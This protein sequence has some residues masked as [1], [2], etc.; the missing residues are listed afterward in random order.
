MPQFKVICTGSSGFIGSA[1]RTKLENNPDY[2]VYTLPHYILQDYEK[3]KSEIGV[4]QP[5]FIFHLAGFGNHSTQIDNQETF[6]ANVIGIWNLLQATKDIPYRAFINFGSSSEYGQ[7]NTP[8]SEL[9]LPEASTMYGCTKIA[10]TY[11][12]RAFAR[13]YDKP[14]VTVRPFSVFGPDE[15]DHRFIPTVIKC[16]LQGKELTLDPNGQ[17]DWIYINNFLDGLGFVADNASLLRGQ[18]VNIG[19]GVQMSNVEIVVGLEMIA[20]KKVKVKI[21]KNMRK[22][23]SEMWQADISKIKKLGWYPKTRFYT[24]LAETYQYYK[25]KYYG[26]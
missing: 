5:N 1:L 7:K 21:V 16:I 26:N 14:I 18:I 25:N 9:D 11:L 19:T 23:D 22:N 13:K 10:G 8:M 15:G 2:K 24:G 3:L 12:S 17:H 6:N 4:I 20:Q